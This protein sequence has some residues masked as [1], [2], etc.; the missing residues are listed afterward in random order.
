M[1]EH[2]SVTS[3]VIVVSIAFIIPVLLHKLRLNVIPVVVAEII[4]G[5]IIGRSGFDLVTPD[6][7]LETLSLLGFIFLM[8]L[9]GLEIDFTAFMNKKKKTTLKEG[10]PFL[11]ALL[12]F[13]GIF[14]ISY[15]LS[16]LLV[17]AGF[18]DNAFL[19]TL[20][21]STISLGVVVPTLK[22]ANIM[23]KPIGQTIL[24]VAV[25]ADLV[26][27]I[28]L[29][30]FVSIY[31][32]SGENMWLLLLL[33]AAG[34]II[35]WAAK[36]YRHQ[37]FF[38]TM[39]KGTVQIDTR[40]IFALIILLVGLSE[41]V[42]AENILGAF[43]AG[44]LVSL[45]SPNLDMIK[46]LDSFG[47][48]FVIPI[49]F[50]MV[51][52]D[53]NVWGLFENTEVL[54]LIPILL[55][56]LFISKFIPALLLLKWYSF[57][58]VMGSAFLLTSTLSLVIAAAS[59]GERIG[60]LDELL[61]SALILVAV[62][63][64]IITPIVFKKVFPKQKTDNAQKVMF[65]GA[66]Q[67]TMPLTLNLDLSRFETHVFHRRQDKVEVISGNTEFAIEEMNDFTLETLE[68]H[69][70]FKGEIVVV[71]TGNEE[72]N[73]QIAKY[74]KERNVPKVIARVDIPE[75]K[76]ELFSLNIDV[77]SV[78]FSTQLV[79]KMMIESPHVVDLFNKTDGG[80]H[81]VDLQNQS[82]VGM[83]LREMPFLGDT[84][85]VRIFRG[86]ESIVPHGDTVLKKDD[87]IVVTGSQKHI[88]QLR[89]LF[90]V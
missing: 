71:A 79:L 30:V 19:M 22:E 37:S 39:T 38:E 32:D 25:I 60:V 26:T 6:I 88:I 52:V 81:E 21:I 53:L 65:V 27:M 62:I 49:F 78:F 24:L 28:L 46:K 31:G 67:L 1:E 87:R 82:I 43:L 58:T 12:V 45:L 83:K 51:G 74:A 61:S 89:N 75:Y 77:F 2:A 59:I 23:N 56:G 70:V 48:G 7:W 90:D 16:V 35:Y 63:S 80:L 55:V 14:I 4:A 42:G 5:I 29:A 13:V 33:F 47:Y 36:K 34:I 15:G 44:V 69:R 64:C 72:L 18:M 40:A 73:Y 17:F 68:K 76:E 86:N 57:N 3:L 54:I 8:F 66:N 50:V 9:S 20:I 41:T 11:V 10:N 85:F 84:V